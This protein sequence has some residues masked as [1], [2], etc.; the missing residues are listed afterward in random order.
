MHIHISYDSSGDARIRFRKR[1]VRVDQDTTCYGTLVHAGIKPDDI[2]TIWRNGRT[3]RHSDIVRASDSVSFTYRYD[4]TVLC[5]IV[6][7]FGLFPLSSRK[8]TS[9]SQI[10][11]RARFDIA[12]IALFRI[13]GRSC[14]PEESV[15]DG[16]IVGFFHTH[17]VRPLRFSIDR[18]PACVSIPIRETLTVRDAII[19]YSDIRFDDILDITVN[20]QPL[21]EAWE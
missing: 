21:F 13:S 15:H 19:G 7:D 5:C 20:G 17:E 4:T 12:S 11:E 3:A 6:R 18:N 9:V 16:A 14:S 8:E 2:G 1:T 10:L